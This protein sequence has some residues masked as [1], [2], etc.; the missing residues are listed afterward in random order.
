MSKF[1]LTCGNCGKK[2]EAVKVAEMARYRCTFCNQINEIT[3]ITI[4]E[5][6]G[7]NYQD[8]L[9][10]IK[11]AIDADSF[12]LLRAKTQI[13]IDHGKL[14]DTQISILRNVLK[15]NFEEGGTIREIAD[16]ILNEVKVKDLEVVNKEGKVTRVIPKASRAINIARTETTR[17]SSLGSIKNYA[18]GDVDD[19][20]WLATPGD[21]TC[22]ICNG[23]NGQI[24][25]VGNGPVP[26]AHSLCRCSV[27]PVVKLE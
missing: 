10:L 9:S 18:D 8:F 24:F 5:W 2:G 14:T 27:M 6:L 26:P 21:R 7:F 13:E 4:K 22:P 25:E 23:L 15:D 17:M 19:Y 3:A 12:E 1:I 11:Q 16:G 20:S